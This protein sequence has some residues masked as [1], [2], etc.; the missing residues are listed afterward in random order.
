MCK[1]VVIETKLMH[2]HVE[3][4]YTKKLVL[5]QVSRKLGS[6]ISMV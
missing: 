2:S 3:M 4:T 6:K 1:D 5:V